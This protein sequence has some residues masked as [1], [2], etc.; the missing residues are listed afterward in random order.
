MQ[1]RSA[2]G[3]YR[4]AQ[5]LT[6]FQAV[7]GKIVSRTQRRHAHV[8]A[9]RNLRQRVTA[10]DDIL[11]LALRRIPDVQGNLRV[12]RRI[13]VKIIAYP[14]QNRIG[15]PSLMTLATQLLF[16]T[17]IRDKRGFDKNRRN[18]RRLQY[19]QT[20]LLN[21]APMYRAHSCQFPNYFVTDVEAGTQRR[22]L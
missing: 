12:G 9:L 17:W 18:V 7:T 11:Q 3:E 19:Q 16:F 2:S 8:V 6:D 13:G 4:Y 15:E 21:L 22:I 10:D 20:S 1:Q 5:F 14:S